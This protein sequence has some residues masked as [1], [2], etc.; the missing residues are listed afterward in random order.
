MSCCFTASS[1]QHV[2][3]DLE[4]RD[5]DDEPV[6]GLALNCGNYTIAALL[7]SSAARVD[8]ATSSGLTLMH[9]AILRD[10]TGAASFLLEHGANINTRYV[11]YSWVPM[12]GQAGI[13][14]SLK[15]EVHPK[16]NI[17][18]LVVFGVLR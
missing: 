5:G 6:L 13:S 10:D 9:K 4:V 7:L 15:G 14:K 18:Y 12:S 8:A 3:V 1:P 11:Q 17:S 2:A 16:M